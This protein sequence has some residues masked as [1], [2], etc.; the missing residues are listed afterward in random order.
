[1][2]SEPRLLIADDVCWESAV[3]PAIVTL[4]SDALPV[5]RMR[6]P[7]PSLVALLPVRLVMTLTG[8]DTNAARALEYAA[9]RRRSRRV[10][11]CVAD[12][13]ARERLLGEKQVRLG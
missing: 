7:P 4:R 5:G 1:M 11:S 3:L 6:I 8:P 2:I 12:R 9:R 10:H 13:G